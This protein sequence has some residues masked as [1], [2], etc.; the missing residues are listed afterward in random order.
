MPELNPKMIKDSFE[1]AKPIATQV[2]D[3]FYEFLFQDYPAAKPLF[4]KVEMEKQKKQLLTSLVF[5]V[6][7]L[8]N[9]PV[10]VDYLKKMGARH[11]AY[12]TDAAHY[13]LVGETLLKTFAFFFK[14]KWTPELK[15]QWSLAYG[16]I[17]KT[18]LEGAQLAPK[19]KLSRAA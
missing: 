15:E 6:T 19:E 2:V 5:I 7:N 10:L 17:A 14:E 9:G 13:P 11:V 12:G 8:E 4:S 3:K 1:L 18:M 16:I